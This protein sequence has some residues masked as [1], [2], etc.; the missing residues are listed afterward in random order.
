MLFRKQNSGMT[1]IEQLDDATAIR[2]LD[3]LR[4]HALDDTHALTEC[5]EDLR[6]PLQAEFGDASASAPVSAGD[7]ARAALE[8]LA[9]DPQLGSNIQAMA[10]QPPTRSFAVVESAL[11]VT[12]C[13]LALQTHVRFHRQKDGRWTLTIDEPSASEGLLTKL[14][15]KLLSF[16]SKPG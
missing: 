11:V 14:G 6:Q 15:E 2:L 4:Q 5:S 3:T 12:A 1:P 16:L 8:L 10:S 7:M 13:L 9:E